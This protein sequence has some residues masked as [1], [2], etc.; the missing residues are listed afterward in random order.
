MR[1]SMHLCILKPRSNRILSPKYKTDSWRLSGNCLDFGW[2]S[3]DTYNLE[4]YPAPEC[5][6]SSELAVHAEEH[7]K[8]S[9]ERRANEA[10]AVNLNKRNYTRNCNGIR[11]K[12]WRSR[13]SPMLKCSNWV[14]NS[15]WVLNSYRYPKFK[16]SP[17]FNWNSIILTT[18]PIQI[19]EMF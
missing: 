9:L 5:C 14:L 4:V 1:H 13:R 17:Q 6:F 11:N 8:A 12:F 7:A 15:S 2:L 16:L 10:G 18:K 3:P 19:S